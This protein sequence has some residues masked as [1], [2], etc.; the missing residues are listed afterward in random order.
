MSKI[1]KASAK[2]RTFKAFNSPFSL[3]DEEFALVEKH[4]DFLTEQYHKL[5]KL[6]IT[7]GIS[8]S[9]DVVKSGVEFRNQFLKSF[10]STKA[11]TSWQ[12]LRFRAEV[13][14]LKTVETNALITIAH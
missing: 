9:K 11:D 7:S 12:D 3:N 5:L 4:Y 2:E 8:Y 10:G 6:Y 14:T 1:S 13:S